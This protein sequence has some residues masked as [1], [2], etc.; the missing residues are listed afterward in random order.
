MQYTIRGIPRA[1]DA[2]L[3]R[4]ARAERR[5][6]N[7]VLVDALASGAGLHGHRESR[8]DL[9]G[10]AGTWQEDPAFDAAVEAQDQVDEAL[11]R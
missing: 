2:A 10:V 5:S 7:A 6:L 9:T 11:W 3:R 8:R 4:R 1:I